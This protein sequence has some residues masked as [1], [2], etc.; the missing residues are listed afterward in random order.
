M[1]GDSVP[2]G[3]LFMQWW[4]AEEAFDLVAVNLSAESALCRVHIPSAQNTPKDWVCTSE[5][6]FSSLPS[7]TPRLVE[8]ALLLAIQPH[9]GQVLRFRS[10]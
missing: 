8:Q 4:S 5:F 2:E 7:V 10:S 6:S 3:V 1:S 9:H